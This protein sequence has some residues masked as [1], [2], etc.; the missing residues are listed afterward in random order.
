MARYL[1]DTNVVI[2]HLNIIL[3]SG[4]IY[5]LTAKSKMI[6]EKQTESNRC[7]LGYL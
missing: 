1:L 4:W 7:S 3:G 6:H 2:W 5:C